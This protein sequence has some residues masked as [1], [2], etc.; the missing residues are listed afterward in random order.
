VAVP[1]VSRPQDV[2]TWF[3]RTLLTPE[4]PEG[5]AAHQAPA[6]GRDG[7][8]GEAAQPCVRIEASRSSA[9][10]AGVAAERS[11][12]ACMGEQGELRQRMLEYALLLI[13]RKWDRMDAAAA[14]DCLPGDIMRRS[15]GCV[16][17]VRLSLQPVLCLSPTALAA[18]PLHTVQRPACAFLFM[19]APSC[20]CCVFESVQC[21]RL[22]ALAAAP[23][24]ACGHTRAAGAGS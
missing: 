22:C 14:L 3:L 17:Q 21:I 9:D 7:Q 12:E 23:G 10:S 5:S 1:A 2:Y 16:L 4:S 6:G 24:C 8:Q 18:R 20:S 15:H 13:G 19:S 11:A